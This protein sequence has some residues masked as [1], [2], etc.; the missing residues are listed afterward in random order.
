MAGS[1]LLAL[2]SCGGE[3][4]SSGTGTT[5]AP[6]PTSSAPA[7]TPTSIDGVEVKSTPCWQPA[8]DVSSKNV[9]TANG[10]KGTIA[11][12]KSLAAGALCDRYYWARFQPA[13]DSKGSFT[14][15]FKKGDVEAPKQVSEP[16]QP[17]WAAFTVGYHATVGEKLTAC[18][19]PS[20]G[21]P[22]CADTTGA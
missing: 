13:A 22:I 20:G 11:V 19:I 21:S 12:R 4:E 18:V 5:P 1:L 17:T 6:V 14:V 2:T 9:A 15:T 16:K 8:D 10:L 7:A 3:N